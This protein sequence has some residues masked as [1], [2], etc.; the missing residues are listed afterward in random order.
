MSA[1]LY[2]IASSYSL[3]YYFWTTRTFLPPFPLTIVTGRLILL[4]A[5]L[6][7]L[8]PWKHDL[9]ADSASSRRGGNSGSGYNNHHHITG[10][11][12]GTKIRIEGLHYNVTE[13]DLRDLLSL[14]GPLKFSRIHYDASGR[15][16]G[17]ADAVFLDAATARATVAK[18]NGVAL[19]G[20]TMKFS[21]VG[22]GD[23]ASAGGAGLRG[24]GGARPS[25]LDR[26]GKSVGGGG[27]AGDG[28][29]MAVDDGNDG[30]RWGG[31]A[32]RRGRRGAAGVR[33]GGRSG[34][35]G[36]SA[37]SAKEPREPRQP[38]KNVS[39]EGLDADLDAYMQGT[40]DAM[41]ADK[42]AAPAAAPAAQ[43][44]VVTYDDL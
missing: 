15:S 40:G 3:E 14:V 13:S 21:V 31:G 7:S 9:W 39:A 42:P 44:Q 29:D 37:R 27:G 17:S 28:D 23:G 41:D 20:E 5:S 16:D 38:K 32:D 35:G 36:R 1:L 11:S 33:G 34:G 22:G 8:Q 30:R 26:L 6:L 12:D 24:A 18:Y 25:V 2:L 43:R 4:L 10:P 19:D